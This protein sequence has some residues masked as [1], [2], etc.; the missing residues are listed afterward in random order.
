MCHGAVAGERLPLTCVCG[1]AILVR[2]RVVGGLGWVDM[3]E[4]AGGASVSIEFMPYSGAIAA[5]DGP[6]SPQALY[7]LQTTSSS[8]Q[9]HRVAL[10]FKPV[11]S[12]HKRLEER[13][14]LSFALA[15]V[16][17]RHDMICETLPR[18]AQDNLCGDEPGYE[19]RI[20][21]SAGIANR[22]YAL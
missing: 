22:L 17:P 20:E 6:Q 1:R 16:T 4:Q 2:E 8:C 15:F 12:R 14:Q 11:P 18:R 19:K 3:L 10:V 9:N 7:Y 21:T 5:Y 13:G